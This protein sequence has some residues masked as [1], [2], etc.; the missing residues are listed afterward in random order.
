MRILF[1]GDIFAKPGLLVMQRF[2]QEHGHSYDFII[3]NG[4]NAADGFGITR[5][6]F[7]AMREAGV[8]VVTLGN[9]TFD[10]REVFEMINETP[11]LLRPLNYPPGVPGL[12]AASFIAR[13]GERITVMQAMGRIFMD[14]LDCPF[15][16]LDEALNTLSVGEPVVVEFHA[17]ATS[18]KKVM[19]YHLQ[20]RVAALIGTHTHVQTAD[21]QIVKGTA[22]I[23]DAGMTGAQDSA[24]GLAFEEVHKRFTT[25]LKQRYKPAERLGTLCG[26]ALTIQ[27]SKARQIERI[28]WRE[29]A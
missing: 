23:T 17:E 9:H 15:R 1:I 5:K 28:Q 7:T 25:Q 12:G 27:G 2:L 26:V 10:N 20:G 13:S 29:G 19:L 3:A 6:H 4:E 24:I 22:Y 8:D 21:E 14:T 11:R 18:E 16:A